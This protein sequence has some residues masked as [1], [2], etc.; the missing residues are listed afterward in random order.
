MDD[1]M[2]T[3]SWELLVTEVASVAPLNLT[4]EA[5]TNLL[6]VAVSVKLAGNCEKIIVFGEIELRIGTG[7]ALPQ[8][9]FSALHAGSNKRTVSSKPR[10]PIRKEEQDMKIPD[11]SVWGLWSERS[12]K[13]LEA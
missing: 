8:R 2:V 6:P 7:R 3:V 13:S 11:G 4:T 5:E 1:V 9:G 10:Q 12:R